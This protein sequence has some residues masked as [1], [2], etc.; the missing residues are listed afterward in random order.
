MIRDELAVPRVKRPSLE[1]FST[2]YLL[3]HKPAILEGII[4]HWP[5]FNQHPWRFG[6]SKSAICMISLISARVHVALSVLCHP[7]PPPPIMKPLIISRRV[8]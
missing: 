1:S 7:L 4:D 3:P 2:N 8:D 5:A 6:L